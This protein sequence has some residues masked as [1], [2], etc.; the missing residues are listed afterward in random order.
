LIRLVLV[1]V[2]GTLVGANGVHAS[3]WPAIE[4][5]H[6]REVHVALCTGRIGRGDALEYARRVEP[7]GLHVFQNGA[8][9]SRPGEP[10][11]YASRLPE[12]PL[13][14]LVAISRRERVPLEAYSETRF[15]IEFHDA[16]TRVHERH[17]GMPAEVVSF[18]Q[19]PERIVRAQWVISERDW[20]RYRD[21]TLALGDVEPNP[22]TAPWSPGTVFSNLT[23]KGTSKVSAMRWLAE[24]LGIA[25][26]SVAM[27]GDAVNDLEVMRGAGL[28]IAMGNAEE[29]VKREADLVV[30]ASDAGG[31]AEAIDAALAWG[32]ESAPH[33]LPLGPALDLHAFQPRDIPDVVRSYLEQAHEAGLAEVRLIHGRGTGFQRERVREVLASHPAVAGYADAPADRGGWGATVVR[34]RS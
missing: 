13:R 1:D 16:L 6:A 31:L 27:V 8:V 28:A 18:D 15:F 17:L 34:L 19:L 3:V 5:A 20:P 24:R 12:A 30:A 33:V 22:A 29:P 11:E 2:D 21:W 9:V 23:A 10:A 4:R 14:A 32:G 25:P 7:D 26:E